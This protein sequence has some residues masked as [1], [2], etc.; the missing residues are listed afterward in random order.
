MN[1]WLWDKKTLDYLKQ[2]IAKEIKQQPPTTTQQALEQAKF[3]QIMR[4]LER[5]ETK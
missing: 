2:E 3:K 1:K 5:Q 4:W